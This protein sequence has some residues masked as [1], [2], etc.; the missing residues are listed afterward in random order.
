MKQLLYLSKVVIIFFVS[1]VLLIA[2]NKDSSQENL[3]TSPIVKT[4]K[5]AEVTK[6]SASFSGRILINGGSQILQVGVCWSTDAE[7]T[8][9]DYVIN[10]QYTSDSISFRINDLIPETFYYFRIFAKNEIGNIGYGNI[11]RFSTFGEVSDIEGNIYKTVRIGEQIWMEQNLKVTKYNS[12]EDINYYSNIEVIPGQIG[13]IYVWHDDISMR[14]TFGAYYNWNTVST[15]KLCPTGW[16]IPSNDEWQV[17]K[18]YLLNNNYAHPV[19]PEAIAKSLASRSLWSE[20]SAHLGEPGV[21]ATE[22]E[23]NNTSGFNAFPAGLR[24]YGAG[25]FY[26]KNRIASFW[27]ANESDSVYAC[28]V[29]IDG[30]MYDFSVNH[31]NDKRDAMPVRCLKD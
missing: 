22:P 19:L 7:P 21:P 20:D 23:S 10:S 16:H 28:S 29:F 9:E 30:I 12:G 24:G 2:C 17:L 26:F 6:T 14:D 18:T 27:S 3:Q 1:F 4:Y 31:I 8:M 13:A 5:V 11:E 25:G 15:D